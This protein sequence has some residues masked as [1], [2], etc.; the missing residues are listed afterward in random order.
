M[1]TK[2]FWIKVTLVVLMLFFIWGNSMLPGT[3]SSA[4]SGFVLKLCRP[5]VSS[6]QRLLSAHGSEL[7]EEYIIRKLAHF[8]EYA[9]LGVLMLAL[10]V[11]PGMKFRVLPPA[12]ACLGAALMDEGIQIFSLGRGPSLRDVGIDFCGA[13]CGIA[14]CAAAVLI[15]RRV[16]TGTKTE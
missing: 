9:V 12:A 2:T 13:V 15:V 1:R 11:Q 10:F 3:I 4:E 8:S 7:T 14:L 16:R 5:F 6:I